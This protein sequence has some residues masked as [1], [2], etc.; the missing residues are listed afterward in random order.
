M[1]NWVVLFVRTGTEEKGVR[2]FKEALNVDEY[3][4]FLPTVETPRRSRGIIH[5][6]RKLLFPGYIFIQT[7]IEPG[8]ISE[9]LKSALKDITYRKNIYAILHYGDNEKDV[10]MRN[11]ERLHWERLFDSEFCIR[12]SVGFIKGDTIRI[13]S[14][15]LVGGMESRIKRI[16]RHKR[17][18]V[19]EMEVMGVVREVRIMLEVAVKV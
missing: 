12:G 8:S 6:E 9:K 16:D 4:P 15:V 13:T 5:K 14:G 3:L 11:Q 17:E 2:A 19:V 18:A 1:K 10:A 7:E